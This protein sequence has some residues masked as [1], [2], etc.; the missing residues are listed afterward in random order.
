MLAEAVVPRLMVVLLEL[1]VLVGVV[2]GIRQQMAQPTLAAVEAVVGKTQTL[3]AA[4][5]APVS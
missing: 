4:Q 2:M 5:A 1:A 3:L